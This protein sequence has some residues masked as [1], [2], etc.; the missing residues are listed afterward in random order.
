MELTALSL[1][2]GVQT[3]A[4]AL[5]L[6]AGYLPDVPRPGVAVF[7]DTGA[8]PPH[9]YETLEY[10]R[11]RLSYPIITASAGDLAADTWTLIRGGAVPHRGRPARTFSLDHPLQTDLPLHGDQGGMTARQCTRNYKIN[12]IIRAIREHAGVSPP[13]LQ[14]TQ[15]LG[16]SIEEVHRVK[17][18]TRRYITHRYPLIEAR[19]RR[20]DCQAYLDTHHPDSPAGRSACYFCPYHS[21]G[22]WRDLQKRY[23]NLYADALAMDAE[24]RAKR[25]LSLSRDPRGLEA[26]MRDN[27]LQG[28]FG[29]G[30]WGDECAGVCGV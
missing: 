30:G 22:E 12:T 19:I 25:G 2:L 16:I 28:R 17:P 14:V 21:K 6:D 27:A 23:P 1:G 3:T 10:L 11:E 29:D 15:Y 18:S 7:A 20:S 24:L 8:E 9:V 5:M 4:L 26:M 13:R